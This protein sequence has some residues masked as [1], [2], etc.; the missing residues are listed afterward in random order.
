[1]SKKER[2]VQMWVAPDFKKGIK[3]L[4]VEEDLSIADLTKKLGCDS[5][6]ERTSTNE[7]KERFRF[8]KF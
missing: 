4:A 3:K 5:L 6:K 2:L 7:K 8:P 1:M